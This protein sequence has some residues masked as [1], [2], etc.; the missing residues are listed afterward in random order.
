LNRSSLEDT[1]LDEHPDG[2]DDSSQFQRSSSSSSIRE[3]SDSDNEKMVSG[4]FLSL[5][6]DDLKIGSLEPVA[7]ATTAAAASSSSTGAQALTPSC[8]GDSFPTLQI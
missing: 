2:R 6:K 1:A 8:C 5:L 7:A 3:E 4:R